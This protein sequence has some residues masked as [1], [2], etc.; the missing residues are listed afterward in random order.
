MDEC[1]GL[2][3]ILDEERQ[4]NPTPNDAKTLLDTGTD[5]ASSDGL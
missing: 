5:R 4:L 1:G 3:E 2:D